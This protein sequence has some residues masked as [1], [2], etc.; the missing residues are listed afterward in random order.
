MTATLD[1]I[2]CTP[3]TVYPRERE[4]IETTIL[5]QMFPWYYIGQQ[6]MNKS[7]EYLPETIRPYISQI[8]SPFLSHTILRRTEEESVNHIDRPL[9]HFSEFYEFF[10]EIFHRYMTENKLKYKKIFRANLN[11]NWHN[12]NGHTEPHRDH[13]W[14]HC[15]FIM[16][17][18]TCDQGQTIVWPDDFS[19]SYMIPCEQ[20]TAVT[21][22]EHWHAH[23]FPAPGTRRVVFV[24]T[25]I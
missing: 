17:L 7:L 16:Y 13:T 19:T 1:L 8:N 3:V 25:Y 6:T 18:N 20:Y 15:N 5:G 12:G 4:I 2:T 9:N 23:R 14:P 24:V 11:L 21:F 22:K 10:I